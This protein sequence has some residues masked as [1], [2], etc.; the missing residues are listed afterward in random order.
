MALFSV[1][2]PDCSALEALSGTGIPA[3]TGSETW[4][5][6]E[7]AVPAAGLTITN[8]AGVAGNFTLGLANDL[9]AVEGLATTGIVRRTGTDTW[10][11]GTAVGLTTE[12]TGTLPVA[13][14]GTGVTSST[15]SGSVVLS[16]APTLT[17]TTTVAT[18]AASG[19]V[20]VNSQTGGVGYTTGAGG[21]ATQATSKSTTVAI[22][23][24]NGNI[25]M[26]NASL[27]AGTAVTFQVTNSAIEA[28]DNFVIQHLSG[29]TV[30]AYVL[31]MAATGAGTADITVTNITAGALG[32]AI[33]LKF[34]LI[35]GS[36]T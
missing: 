5:L 23:R 30:G 7:I 4:A 18:I 6:R 1:E 11:A 19:F 9:S 31:R 16:A 3:R 13:N 33:V 34:S 26:H 22:N 17:G 32:E 24:A 20:R 28:N 25:T 21:T 29:G 15:G 14:G 36:I 35:K 8:P 10:S 27:G 2:Y 12:V